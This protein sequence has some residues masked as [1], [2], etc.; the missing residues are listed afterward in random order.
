[1][2]DNVIEDLAQLSSHGQQ[3]WL[4][5]AGASLE[6]NL[7]LVSGLTKRVRTV[8]AN[9][10]FE[11]ETHPNSTIG[12]L[13]D[14]LRADIGPHATIEDILDH[15]A[16][17]LS[18]ARR[19]AD[20]RVLVRMVTP[21]GES[22]MEQFAFPELQFV[23]QRILQA[24][25][26][27]LRWGYVHSENQEDCREGTPEKPILTIQNHLSFMDVLFGVLR[28]GR[29]LRTQPIEFFTTNYDTLIEDALALCAISYTDGF[30][31]G[32]VA[33]WKP[34][35]LATATSEGQ[36]IRAKVTKIHGSIDWTRL[37]DT[38][39]RRR[40][41]DSYPE[42]ETDLLIYP[43][44]HKY[45][46]TKREPFD[47]LFGQFRKS[48]RRRSPQ[49][50]FSCGHGFGDEHVN[51]EILLALKETDSQLTLVIFSRKRDGSAAEWQRREFGER[52]YMV[53][54]DGIWRGNDGPYLQPPDN[55]LHNWWTFSGMT[56]F[57]RN[58]EEYE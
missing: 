37:G 29:E 23:H 57:L 33:H 49:V 41:S 5:G 53:T 42:G 19:S 38:V 35:M 21:D 22:Q 2:V 44:A 48:L 27:T 7:P 11:Q 3:I 56:S 34:S 39:V 58:P 18:I 14:G 50:L 51:Q 4:L 54:E 17:H 16:D 25:R 31:G 10:P 46:L 8:L 52:I 26:D 40:I 30:C 1:M 55:R 6:A 47:T 24:I 15:L 12:H 28:A 45:E 20:Q 9:T 43:Q 32:A 13:I 36:A